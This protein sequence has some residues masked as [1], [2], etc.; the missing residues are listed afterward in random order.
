MAGVA[1]QKVDPAGPLRP[2]GDGV[3]VGAAP[4]RERRQAADGL[5]PAQGVERVLDAQHRRGVDRPAPEQARVQPSGGID[6]TEYLGQGAVGGPG[7]EAFDGARAERQHAV[8]RLP[9]QRLLPGPRG[10]V[11]AGPRQVHGEGGRSGVADRQPGAVLGDPVAVRDADAGGRAV[12]DEDEVVVGRDAAQVGE[13]TVGR[14][15][16][17]RAGDAQPVGYVGRPAG[18]ETLP[19]QHVDAARAEQRPQR[20]LERPGVGSGEDPRAA[21]R[22]AFP[23]A[24][25]CGPGPRRCATP[26]RRRG[27]T[28]P[29]RRRA[30]PR[31]TTRAAW[32]TA[33]TKSR[34]WPGGRPASGRRPWRRRRCKGEPGAKH[35]R[36]APPRQRGPS[37]RPGIRFE[38]RRSAQRLRYRPAKRPG[39]DRTGVTGTRPPRIT[40]PPPGVTPPAPPLRVVARGGKGKTSTRILRNRAPRP[41]R[42]SPRIRGN[43]RY[44]A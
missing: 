30:A 12:P 36:P 43:R 42:I 33:P 5:G 38:N 39:R 41:R 11:E 37:S 31:A 6:E 17:A 27:A 7:F 34:G 8:L 25:G 1:A 23:A 14:L 10:D 20:G 40:V 9:S 16:D 3:E 4:R 19:G 32:R 35:R 26:R 18:A 22:R 24:R 15:V 2:R 28:A 13:R 29:P 44:R 21:S